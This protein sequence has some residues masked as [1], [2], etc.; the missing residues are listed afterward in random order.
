MM[1]TTL[2]GVAALF[3]AT[4]GACFFACWLA[5]RGTR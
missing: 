1:P 5:D 4:I 2:L 3:I